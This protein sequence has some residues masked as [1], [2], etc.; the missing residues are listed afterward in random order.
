MKSAIYIL[1][2]LTLILFSCKK[3]SEVTPSVKGYS[4]AGLTVGK[5]VV[6]D[7][8]SIF[9]DDFDN[10][11][12]QFRFQ[13]KELIHSKYIDAEGEEAY[14]IERYKKD[15]AVSSNF[16]LVEVWNSKITPTNFQQVENNERFVKLIFPVKQGKVWNGNSFNNRTPW[17][18]EFVSVHLPEQ[19]GATLLDS[20]STVTQFDDGDE[21]LIQRQF[22]QEK[23]ASK[24][25]MVYKKVIDIQKAF[26]NQTGFYENS[27]GV[28]VTYTLNSY[29]AN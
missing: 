3:E 13:I 24:I 6:Y 11:V 12:N 1:L 26:N 14:R 2:G 29:G 17:D 18:Y 21:I 22:Y 4:Y 10:S 25:G 16:E 5:Y 19:I 15:T 8:D 27:L 7:V 20:V 28:D 23:Y 9:Y